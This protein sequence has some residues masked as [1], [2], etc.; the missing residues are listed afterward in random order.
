M[1]SQSR[2]K[3]TRLCRV[4][5]EFNSSSSQELVEH[6]DFCQRMKEIGLDL[7]GGILDPKKE[8]ELW[9]PYMP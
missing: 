7:P 1:G 9:L 2:V 4:C 3:K 5:Q 6:A 8:R